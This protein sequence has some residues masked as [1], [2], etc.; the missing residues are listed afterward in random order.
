MNSWECGVVTSHFVVPLRFTSHVWQF[1]RA[2]ATVHQSSSIEHFLDYTQ[3]HPALQ[4]IPAHSTP[5]LCLRWLAL[6]RDMR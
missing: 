5:E 3:I 4:Q 6:D 1:L 2:M